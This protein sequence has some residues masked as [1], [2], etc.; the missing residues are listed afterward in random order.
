MSKI[1]A[2]RCLLFVPGNRP[3]RYQ[4]AIQS[5]ADMVCIDLEDAT[6]FAEK[7]SA[8]ASALAFA[9][10][11]QGSTELVIRANSLRSA[12]G[13]ADLLAF[14]QAS[15][16]ALLML[17]KVEA[18]T[19][20]EI[21]AQVLGLQQ[22]RLIA[23]L[24]SAQGI[25]RAFAIAR[26]PKLAALMLGGADYCAELGAKMTPNAL[27]YPRARIA[28]AVASVGLF[29]IDVPFL[30]IHD[31]AGVSNETRLVAELG[32]SCKSAIHPAQV[33]PIQ[34]TL[35]PTESEITHAQALLSAFHA[36]PHAAI[37]YQ[38]KLIDR[39]I[40]LAAERVLRRAG[41]LKS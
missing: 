9:A 21:A 41:L 26:A 10:Q 20:V 18:A 3:E 39:P 11:Y 35:R 24:E 5:G 34:A 40:V 19:E 36:S 32:I 1:S 31:V 38:G 22:A 7:T 6:P 15:C 14:Q 4:K 8:R 16:Q 25:E 17:A 23:L 28:A 29:A 2:R 33:A 30:D 37:A 27:L 12:E 13:L